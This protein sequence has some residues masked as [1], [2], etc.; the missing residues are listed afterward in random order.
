MR[1]AYLDGFSGISGDMFLGALVD[2]GVS[3]E[4]LQHTVAALNVGAN[5]EQSRVDRSGISATKIDVIVDGKKDQ[6]R[7]EYWETKRAHSH[8]DS[9]HVHESEGSEQQEH[10]HGR[11]LGEILKLIAAAEISEGARKTA[12]A[13]FTALGE[14]E[15]KVHNVD[16]QKVHFHEVG[17]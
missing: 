14:A 16:V 9:G 8:G 10:S 5:L 1:I 2:A 3:F 7:E 6:P 15:A 4:L 11:H 13:I 12:C 17:A